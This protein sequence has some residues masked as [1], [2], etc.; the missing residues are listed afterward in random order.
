VLVNNAISKK[1]HE[2]KIIND[3][4]ANFVFIASHDLR[5]PLR[6]I[7]FFSNQLIDREA[8]RIS[9]K[10]RELTGKIQASV[11]RLNALIED[12]LAYS[13]TASTPRTSRTRVNLNNL[14]QQVL[15]SLTKSIEEKN[16]S[17]AVDP[18]TELWAD[19]IQLSQLLLN[20]ISNAIKFQP[21]DRTPVVNISGFSL[22]GKQIGSDLANDNTRYFRLE[23]MDNGIGFDPKYAD[24]IF[25][26]F[27]RLHS[28][29]EYPGTGMGLAI[30]KKIVEN[31]NGFMVAKGMP[32][33]GAVFYCYFPV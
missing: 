24:R 26:M 6:K 27:Q 23:V 33:I 32:G 10:G 18:L 9:S 5:E 3:E 8:S 31:H 11:Q 13:Q 17:I 29:N 14:V 28:K 1:N 30:C 19:P 12:I 21:K 25:H 22:L 2:L 4:L 15:G 20:L 7:L 16:V